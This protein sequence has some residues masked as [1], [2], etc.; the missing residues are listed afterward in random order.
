[1]NPRS[2]CFLSLII[3]ILLISLSAT[4]QEFDKRSIS[5]I[6]T[7]D[8]VQKINI[9]NIEYWVSNNGQGATD[10]SWGHSLGFYWPKHTTSSAIYQD[11]FALVGKVKLPNGTTELRAAGGL[12]LGGFQAGRVLEYGKIESGVYLPAIADNPSKVENRI[13]KI[14]KKWEYLPNSDPNKIQLQKDYLEW[15][16]IQGAPVS[17]NGS[18]FHLGDQTLFYVSND[19]SESRSVSSFGSKPMGIEMLTTIW[20]YKSFA[21]ADV[22]FVQRKFINKS[23]LQIDSAYF[24]IYSDP[25]IGDVGNDFAGCDSV[26]G[27]IYGYQ[28]GNQPDLT[29]GYPS[30]SI[31][32]LFIETPLSKFSTISDTA[33]I[34]RNLIPGKKNIGMSAVFGITKAISDNDDIYIGYSNAANQIFNYSRG[35]TKSGKQQLDFFG[36]STKFAFSGD[37][38]N[39]TGD[40]F[41]LY[42]YPGDIKLFGT[43]GP[44][45]FQPGDSQTVVYAI[46]IAK[47]RNNVDGVREIKKFSA[48]IKD[49]YCEKINLPDTATVLS[50][51][52]SNGKQ[53]IMVKYPYLSEESVSIEFNPVKNLE[54]Q[55]SFNLKRSSDFLEW[56]SDTLVDAKK[57]PY[58]YRFL[59]QG[60]DKIKSLPIPSHFISFRPFP[61]ISNY[62]IITETG[63]QDGYLNKNE[64]IAI[65]LSF[66]NQD[67]LLPIEN[68]SIYWA[69]KSTYYFEPNQTISIKEPLVLNNNIFY[70]FYINGK[71]DITFDEFTIPFN[72]NIPAKNYV[73]E[74]QDSILAI[75]KL[76]SEVNNFEI[77]IADQTLITGHDYRIDFVKV[78]HVID[79]RLNDESIGK[80][81]AD[82]VQFKN[83]FCINS[84]D[85]SKF[86]YDGLLFISQSNDAGSQN[87]WD[88]SGN[89]NWV[90]Q[91]FFPNFYSKSATSFLKSKI[92][93]PED[94]VSVKI[95]FAEGD[96]Q[97][98]PDQ[99]SKAYMYKMLQDSSWKYLGLGDVP[100]KVWDTENNKQLNICT[101]D[102]GD[103]LWNMGWTGT[104]FPDLIGNNEWILIMKS[105]YDLNSL[106]DYVKIGPNEDVM[107]FLWPKRRNS[108]SKYLNKSFSMSLSRNKINK[109]GDEILFTAPKPRPIAGYKGS[110]FVIL[111]KNYPNPFNPTTTIHFDLGR[112]YSNVTL[113]VYNILGQQVKILKNE[114]MLLGSYNINWDGKNEYK[115][116]VSS[117]IYF[118]RLVAE[119]FSQTK[120]MLLIK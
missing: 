42:N 96:K 87:H 66:K 113:I 116:S 88:A 36:H 112:D 106:Y 10:P 20:A 50:F 89:D 24:S 22:I 54:N 102:D 60:K 52:D 80:V 92:I 39:R 15:P 118:Y 45:S 82:S 65:E 12:F 51:N 4:S 31:G 47:G 19:L 56:I 90:T 44:F 57:Y 74:I 46:L 76:N 77:R 107:Y 23:G 81:V 21:F 33:I 59:I 26:L 73:T 37:P 2:A 38:V 79:W 69:P 98:F 13:Y 35:L 99:W 70:N 78:G 1:M 114:P 43:T 48:S 7:N 8:D 55:F 28:I 72:I 40:L 61:T 64:S 71:V 109:P 18:P 117:G 63:N 83:F 108:F 27:L 91:N 3:F 115:S 14:Q 94:Y 84:N 34:D 11:G 93:E 111:D 29:Y 5:K 58:T 110:P 25:D 67:Q 75:S 97:S 62:R 100:F 95:D 30:P 6:S 49:W 120:K 41:D 32:Y 16:S 119:D 86:V 103:L 17:E 9:N 53:R 68:F 101:R 105:N 85:A 104:N